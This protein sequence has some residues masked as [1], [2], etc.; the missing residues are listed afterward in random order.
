M[1]SSEPPL[2]PGYSQDSPE[3]E[4]ETENLIEIGLEAGELAHR[5]ANLLG[6]TPDCLDD[7]NREIRERYPASADQLEAIADNIRNILQL[8]DRLAVEM[9]TRPGA[10]IETSAQEIVKRALAFYPCPAYVEVTLACDED[11][12]S[13]VAVE[14]IHEAIGNIVKNAVQELEARGGQGKIEIRAQRAEGGVEFQITD[15]GRG[16]VA[17]EQERVFHLFHGT[18]RTGRNLGYG[19]FYARRRV[20]ASGGRIRMRSE[21]GQGTT[22]VVLLPACAEG[23]IK[24]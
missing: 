21:V 14:G 1:P 16:I 11:L 4:R 7:I 8:T 15:N 2:Q 6:W 13:I 9:Q 24:L 18:K 5:L 20:I 19:L 3:N 12:P 10:R 22:F 17:S 23:E